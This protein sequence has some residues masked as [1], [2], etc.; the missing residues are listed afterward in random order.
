[1]GAS[2]MQ[3]PFSREPLYIYL[4]CSP[5]LHVLCLQFCGPSLGYSTAAVHHCA[6]S[7]MDRPL[8]GIVI[9]YRNTFIHA[10]DDKE[11]QGLQGEA[12]SHSAP[13]SLQSIAEPEEK[14]KHEIQNKNAQHNIQNKKYCSAQD[15]EGNPEGAPEAAKATDEAEA[16]ATVGRR[17]RWSRINSGVFPEQT[18]TSSSRG[19]EGGE[20]GAPAT[21]EG[22][23]S[24]VGRM[25]RSTV[26]EGEPEEEPEGE[27]EG[28][29]G[30]TRK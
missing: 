20:R 8:K 5:C 3:Y 17:N 10:A 1:M 7:C 26:P 25:R 6:M 9:S 16:S 14:Q 19:E 4:L 2:P 29:P 12:R 23:A 18:A 28:E 13:P 21:H 24:R 27:P 15:S 30:T 11:G 22:E